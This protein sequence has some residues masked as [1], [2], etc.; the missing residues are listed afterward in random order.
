MFICPRE[1]IYVSILL[2][3]YNINILAI[4]ARSATAPRQLPTN[5]LSNAAADDH[6]WFITG[7]DNFKNI[8]FNDNILTS[9]LYDD[10]HWD[11]IYDKPQ[12]WH[13]VR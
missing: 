13:P 11:L 4:Y 6:I 3:Y 2:M 10:I 12:W 8:F 9:A 1:Q 5:N 7:S